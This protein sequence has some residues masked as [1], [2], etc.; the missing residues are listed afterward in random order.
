MDKKQLIDELELLAEQLEFKAGL[1]DI[2]GKTEERFVEDAINVEMPEK[3]PVDN[4]QKAREREDK[5]KAELGSKKKT[6][7]IKMYISAGIGVVSLI[8]FITGLW[9]I[10]V[11]GLVLG[12]YLA[13][14]GFVKR[15]K[16][17]EELE[18]VGDDCEKAKAQDEE[19]KRYNEN[20]YV[21]FL[22][23]YN[24][25][26]E[27]LSEIY[28][29]GY[30]EAKV[31]LEELKGVM[32]EREPILS[33]KY[34]GEIKRIIDALKEGRADCLSEAI[35]VSLSDIQAEKM[36]NE[37]LRQTQI[38]EESARYQRQLE[39]RQLAETRRHNQQMEMAAK[40]SA[41]A[42]KRTADAKCSTCKKYYFCNK[43]TC[44][45]YEKADRS[46]IVL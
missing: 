28:R 21:E 12:G 42:A 40:Q 13:W 45:G 9:F 11:F 31:T 20:E 34:H 18:R 7:E 15:G 41:A 46:H 10:G 26:R 14:D 8:F 6:E 39:E 23:A 29:K 27:R 30:P 19:N 37:Q 36:L 3:L 43:K 38:Q 35:N 22:N 33:P 32:A 16:I 2:V 1:E 4:Y 24:Q 25:E 5:R 17:V 44:I